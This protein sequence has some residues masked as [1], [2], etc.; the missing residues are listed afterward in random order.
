[1]ISTLKDVGLIL[2]LSANVLLL[3]FLARRGPA[4]PGSSPPLG[5][6]HSPGS[7]RPISDGDLARVREQALAGNM[8]PAIKLYREATGCGLKEAKDAVEALRRN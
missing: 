3:W 2:S 7:P 6:A 5:G 4:S 8:I 1:M